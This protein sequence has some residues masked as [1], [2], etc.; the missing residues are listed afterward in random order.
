MQH[1]RFLNAL[2]QLK[3][4]RVP[5]PTVT[6]VFLDVYAEYKDHANYR[7]P[8]RDLIDNLATEELI[9]L[10]KSKQLW[11]SI[12][13][14]KLPTWV[15]LI[16]I[17]QPKERIDSITWL[18]ELSPVASTLRHATQL[19]DLARINA[20][21]IEHRG[22]LHSVPFRER[23]LKIFGDE[24]YLDSKIHTGHLFS[25]LL[26]LETIFA[27]EAHEPMPY[28][29]PPSLI[30]DRPVLVLENHHSFASFVAANAEQNAFSAVCYASGNTLTKRESSLE[31]IGKSVHSTRF[32]YLG[33]IDPRGLAI[34]IAVSKSRLKRGAPALLP[35]TTLY[36]WLLENGRPGSLSHRQATTI[37]MN[38][39]KE[40]FTDFDYG[41]QKMQSLFDSSYRI[42]QEHLGLEELSKLDLKTIT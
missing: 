12:G 2:S 7:E 5:L 22:T 37:D 9:V 33:D 34:P 4:K 6:A 32:L 39:V 25:G 23:S 1:K 13:Y 41:I 27:F 10:P 14:P 3:N 17:E 30:T 20:Y 18:P 28:E 24:H 11:D 15:R 29:R 40:W 31:S 36:H 26:P 19:R 35:A 38:L 16:E 21:L 42:P 8:L